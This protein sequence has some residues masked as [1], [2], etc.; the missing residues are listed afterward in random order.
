V[1]KQVQVG[2]TNDKF[3]VIEKG[4]TAGEQIAM[5]PKQFG[6]RIE[7]PTPV[8]YP[9]TKPTQIARRR[10]ADGGTKLAK[11]DVTLPAERKA[12]TR[13]KAVGA[14]SVEVNSP[15]HGAGL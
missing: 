13:L 12:G 9:S 14:V 11:S 6:E 2:P 15:N 8:E 4:L 7:L 10:K 5:A 3:V 1:A